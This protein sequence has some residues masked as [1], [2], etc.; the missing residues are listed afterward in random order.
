MNIRILQR[1]QID[2]A[3]WNFI[4]DE[5]VNGIVYA[6]TWY[7]D[8]VSPGWG[9]LVSDNYE[10]I[11]PLP[12]CEKYCQK[13]ILQPLFAQQLGLF[14]NS[15]VTPEILDEFLSL[16]KLNFKYVELNLNTINKTVEFAKYA[17]ERV[18]YHLCLVQPYSNIQKKYKVNTKRNCLKSFALGVEVHKNIPSDTFLD[19]YFQNAAHSVNSGMKSKISTLVEVLVKHKYAE[20]VGARVGN[21]SLCAVA[22]LVRSNGKLIYLLAASSAIGKQNRA[23]FSIVDQVIRWSAE[24]NVVL[25]FEGSMIPSVARFYAGFGAQPCSYQRI[26][27]NRLSFPY[28]V[29]LFFKQ[30]FLK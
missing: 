12:K 30:K 25:D 13:L 28:K 19:F 5:A 18:T 1:E 21:G 4:V 7:L 10:Y 27:V 11:F 20:I 2:D 8:V 15:A 26:V 17:H 29:G 24:D 3:R 9:A 14:S 16:L 6:Y 23:M 22:L